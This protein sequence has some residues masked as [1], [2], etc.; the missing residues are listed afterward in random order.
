ME[1]DAIAKLLGEWSEG[2]GAGAIAL[3]IGLAVLFSVIIGCERATKR[4]TAGLRTFMIVGLASCLAALCDQYC[5]LGLGA[6][7]GF[8]VAGSVVAL[9]ILGSN[10]ILFSSK[11]KLKGLTTSVSIWANGMISAAIGF[12]LY[13]A[14][15]IGFAVLMCSI[16][17]F[18]D[19][20]TRFKNRSSHFEVHLELKA[21]NLLHEFTATIREFG[22]KIN[23]IENNPA[24]ANSGLGVYTVTLTVMKAELKKKTHQ[25]IIAALSELD[26][27]SYIEEME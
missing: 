22:L 10:T 18:P 6:S 5:V 16:S 27:V 19:L 12:G 7:C 9:A 24:Y 2:T 8:I 23:E 20:E 21:R 11:N 1:T 3:K 14:G 26:C 15:L 25:E 17:L 13:T 4:H